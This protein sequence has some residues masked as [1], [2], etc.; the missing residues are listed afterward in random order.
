MGLGQRQPHSDSE[1]MNSERVKLL[2]STG[3][4]SPS[5]ILEF[6]SFFFFF[7]LV[8]GLEFRAFT[9]SHSASPFF[10][11]GIFEIVSH[12]LFAQAGFEPQTS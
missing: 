6:F 3:F 11:K 10:V 9:L 2:P 8:L 4:W 1:F 7:N 5:G 12:E